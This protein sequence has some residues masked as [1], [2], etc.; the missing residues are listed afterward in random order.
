MKYQFLVTTEV[1]EPPPGHGAAL[2]RRLER[3]AHFAISPEATVT[4][5]AEPEPPV[6]T[7]ECD[8]DAVDWFGFGLACAAI[9]CIVGLVAAAVLS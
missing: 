9:G 6:L 4:E 8:H 1:V 3:E 7:A 5:Y 2:R